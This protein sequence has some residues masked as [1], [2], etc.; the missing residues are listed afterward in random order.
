M[1]LPT[2]VSKLRGGSGAG[3]SAS[4]ALIARQSPDGSRRPPGLAVL[5]VGT[6]EPRPRRDITV[7]KKE[8][9]VLPRV[10][11]IRTSAAPSALR[12]LNVRIKWLAVID[13]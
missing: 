4:D 12:T 10:G 3:H 2:M 6:E 9:A 8:K 13:V 11:N 7:A 1:A 5:R